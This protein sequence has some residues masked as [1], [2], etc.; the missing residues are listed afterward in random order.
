MDFEE[1]MWRVPHDTMTNVELK[2]C[3]FHFA[4]ALLRKV[5]ALG[6]QPAYT[7]DNGTFRLLKKFMVLCFL[8]AQHTYR[9]HCQETA[10]ISKY[11]CPGTVCGLFGQKIY[12]MCSEHPAS[13]ISIHTNDDLE[14]W[15]NSLKS[16][17]SMQMPIYLI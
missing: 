1:L 13:W 2:D 14:G 15:H 7:S 3:A 4:Q 5:Q 9:A 6:L 11:S 10:N 12:L 17:G 8:S 16:R